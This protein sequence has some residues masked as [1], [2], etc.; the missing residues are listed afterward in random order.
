MEPALVWVYNTRPGKVKFAKRVFLFVVEGEEI[1]PLNSEDV[2]VAHRRGNLLYYDF[3]SGGVSLS[4]HDERQHFSCS[5]RSVTQNRFDV[6]THTHAHTTH[7]THSTHP[8][9]AP[10]AEEDAAPEEDPAADAASR[11]LLRALSLSSTSS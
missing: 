9:A 1:L 6:S 5:F 7:T 3:C 2:P 11:A 10:E 8:D 4:S